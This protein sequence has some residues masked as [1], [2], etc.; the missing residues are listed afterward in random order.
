MLQE[1]F[2]LLGVE[3]TSAGVAQVRLTTFVVAVTIGRG[4]RYFGE[5]LLALW[6]GEAALAFLRDNAHMVGLWIGMAILVGGAG[7]ILWK[8]RRR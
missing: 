8:K 4:V 3:Q 1:A 5:G 6:Y 2:R 7:F